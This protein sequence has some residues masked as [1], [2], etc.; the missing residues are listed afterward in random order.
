M[1]PVSSDILFTNTGGTGL[2]VAIS[3]HENGVNFRIDYPEI[4][5]NWVKTVILR[6]ESDNM[7]VTNRSLGRI[8]Q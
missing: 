7:F 2:R 8:N 1:N 4:D 3:V 5:F 6:K